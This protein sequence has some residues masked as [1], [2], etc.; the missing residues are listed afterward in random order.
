M[1]V[2]KRIIVELV[3][4]LYI[5]ARNRFI[6]ILIRD[7][8]IHK[9]ADKTDADKLREREKLEGPKRDSWRSAGMFSWRPGSCTNTCCRHM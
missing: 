7:R 4:F 5:A 2:D 9:T 1:A 8:K 6:S 3:S